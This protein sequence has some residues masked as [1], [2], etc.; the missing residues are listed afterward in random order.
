VI[1]YPPNAP[2]GY[3]IFSVFNVTVSKTLNVTTV[4]LTESFECG[5]TGLQPFII[6]N[7]TWN[8]ITNYSVNSTACTITFAIP[9]DPVIALG[10][11][12]AAA[13]PV[14]KKPVTTTVQPIIVIVP[15][16]LQKVV[17]Q[18]TRDAVGTVLVIVGIMAIIGGAYSVSLNK[19]RKKYA[20]KAKAKKGTSNKKDQK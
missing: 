8:P 13:S 20:Y 12:L 11:S 18:A 14:L 2:A 1:T 19:K 10:Q 7:G 16:S 6:Q 9:A 5:L 15:E 4:S 17:S 3:T